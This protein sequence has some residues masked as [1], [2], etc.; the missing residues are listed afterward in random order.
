MAGGGQAGDSAGAGPSSGGAAAAQERRDAPPDGAAAWA[1]LPPDVT[2]AV[3]SR[4]SP[5]DLARAATAC[6]ELRNSARRLQAVARVLRVPP[7]LSY[8]ALAAMVRA[9]PRAPRVDVSRAAAR[10]GHWAAAAAAAPG[11]EGAAARRLREAALQEQ[12]AHL[13]QTLLAV[14]DGSGGRRRSDGGGGGA[15]GGGAGPVRGLV[16]RGLE[17]MS[18]AVLREG[19]GSLT[20]LRCQGPSREHVSDSGPPGGASGH[21]GRA[22]LLSRGASPL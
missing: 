18:D 8:P 12:E 17:S 11:A 21:G 7:G 2:F 1:S 4:L 6:R 20:A 13:F 19:L 10:R 5:S 16:A 3:L 22:R 14:A 15:D 9:H